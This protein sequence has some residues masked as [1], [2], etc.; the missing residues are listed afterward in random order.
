MLTPK[1]RQKQVPAVDVQISSK[2]F[3]YQGKDTSSSNASAFISK[4]VAPAKLRPNSHKDW[5]SDFNPSRKYQSHHALWCL[6]FSRQRSSLCPLA[7]LWLHLTR[8][9][10]LVL[11]LILFLFIFGYIMLA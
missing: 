4:F 6:T 1:P 5:E 9:G 10:T 3:S 11:Q 7:A 2:I 8:A